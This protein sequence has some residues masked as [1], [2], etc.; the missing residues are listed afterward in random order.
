MNQP[1]VYVCPL[2]LEPSSD[3][4]YLNEPNQDQKNQPANPKTHKV[5]ECLLKP[6]SLGVICYAELFW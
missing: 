1:Q 2:L 3:L 6:L 5:N 4:R